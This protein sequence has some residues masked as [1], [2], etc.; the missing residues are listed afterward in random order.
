MMK[1]FLSTCVVLALIAGGAAV[2]LAPTEEVP[3]FT[4]TADVEQAPNLFEGGGVMVRGV[5]IGTITKLTPTPDAVRVTMEIEEGV[6]IPADARLAIVPITVIADRYVQFY[7]AY[8]S[9]PVL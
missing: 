8:D 1:R 9:G 5:E 2:Y 4:V 6:K 3:T 7:P